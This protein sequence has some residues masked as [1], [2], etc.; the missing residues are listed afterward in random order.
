MIGLNGQA[1]RDQLDRHF[2]EVGKNLVER[3]GRSSY[4]INDDDGNTRLGRQMF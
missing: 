3:G 1:F 2:C 4:V